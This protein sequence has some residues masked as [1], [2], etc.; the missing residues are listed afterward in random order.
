MGK[1]QVCI[2]TVC[3]ICQ[4]MLVQ[5][6]HMYLELNAL[7][8]AGPKTIFAQERRRILVVEAGLVEALH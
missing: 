3:P 8:K 7:N 6:S 5:S 4:M 1:H 2:N